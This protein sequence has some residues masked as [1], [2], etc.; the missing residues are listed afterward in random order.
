MSTPGRRPPEADVLRQAHGLPQDGHAPGLSPQ[1]ELR[2]AQHEGTPVRTVHADAAPHPW[3]DAAQGWDQHASVIRTWLRGATAAM[4]DAA[5]LTPGARV[6]DIAA[7][8]G[9]QTLDIAQRIGPGG[10][11]LATDI[12]PRILSLAHDRL[13][14][15]GIAT[16]ATR[17]ADA[18]ALGLAGA[19]FDAAVCR[20]GLMFCTA[21]LQALQGAHAAL[22]PGGRFSALVF[23]TPQANPCLVIL[24]RT[25]QRHAGVPAGDPFEPGTLMS[26]G[27][28]GLMQRLLHAAG[29]ADIAVQPMAAPFALPSVQQYIAFVRSSASPVMQLLKALPPAAQAAAWD[30]MTAQLQAFST[31]EGWAGPNELLLCSATAG[32]GAP[33]NHALP[34]APT[35]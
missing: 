35:P 23:S 6:L 21:P 15:A 1:G 3:D 4:L 30:D 20:L 5:H 18:Q 24:A 29:F 32:A 13:R 11:V 9:D 14:A 26:L 31:L 22:R 33:D 16:A 27:Q 34:G 12:S 10:A 19:N 8:A 7:G 17:V 25:A 28:P 2:S